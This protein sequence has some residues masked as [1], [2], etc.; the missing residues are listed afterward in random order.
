MKP[1]I[2]VTLTALV[3]LSIA[4]AFQ[5]KEEKLM[6]KTD[7]KSDYPI[8]DIILHR[9][10]PRALLP[11]ISDKELM[12]IFEAGRWAASSYNNQPWRF[13]Y[14]K[15]GST[16]WQTFLNLLAP[17]NQLWAKNA[18]VLVL[19]I[20]KKT[21]DHNGNPYKTHSFEAGSAVQNMALQAAT[22]G[23][24]IHGMGGFD[25]EKARTELNV[26]D[27]FEVEAMLAIGKVAPKENL[28]QEL[29]NYEK[30]SNRKPLEEVVTEGSFKS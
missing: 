23:L 7:R 19:V 4:Y 20:S 12:T 30:P 27:D 22:M 13:L 11:E 9:W 6:L 10:S 8:L 29:Q 15:N 17:A 26:P 5:H 25:Y 16:S 18:A 14:A 3:T 24:A 21:F 1:Y 28:P 2:L